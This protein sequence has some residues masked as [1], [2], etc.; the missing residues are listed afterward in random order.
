V[1]L[2]GDGEDWLG[3]GVS[4]LAQKKLD[5][6]E[7]TLRGAQNLL[8]D[9]PF[10]SLQLAR[11]MKE[12]SDRKGERENA[13]RAIQIDNNSVDAWVYLA[14]SVREQS[15]DDAMVKQV[16]ELAN[17]PVNTK[18]AAP[19]IALQ[20]FFA[21]NAKDEAARDRAIGY[22][23]KAVERAPG[24]PLALVCLS[25]LY[26]QAGKIEDVIKLLAPHEALMQRDV[27]VAHNYF[28]AL[29]QLR[30]MQRLT[31]LLNKLATSQVRE[32]KQ[33]A[34]ERSRALQQM[35]A[36]QQQQLAGAAQVR[37]PA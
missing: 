25:A 19:Y 22:A 27:R 5:K 2:G 8:K 17:A 31:A 18:S 15:G 29:L 26:G 4:Q 9:S 28:E 37:P 32:V 1:A 10:P 24:D 35:L 36:Q 21:A 13:E 7:A 6:A 11:L 33:F 16:E 12:K 20:G 23:K 3:L 34:I 30:D 14:S